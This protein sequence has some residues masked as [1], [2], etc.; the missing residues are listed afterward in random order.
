MLTASQINDKGRSLGFD[1]VGIS[2][3]GP[4]PESVFYSRWLEKGYGADMHYLEKQ[5]AAKL[6]LE[7]LGL[8]NTTAAGEDKKIKPRTGR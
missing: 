3:I 4:F 5:E 1:V 8:I 2:P 7:K 6:T